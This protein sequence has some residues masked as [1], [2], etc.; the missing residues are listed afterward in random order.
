MLA[1]IVDIVHY[2]HVMR[3]VS[4]DTLHCAANLYVVLTTIWCKMQHSA[5]Q[6]NGF[7]KQCITLGA[8]HDAYNCSHNAL[9][10]ALRHSSF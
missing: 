6:C 10:N 2:T 4:E 8:M 3:Y 7:N 5:K 9:P 1:C